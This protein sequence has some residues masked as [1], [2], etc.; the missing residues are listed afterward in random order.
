MA[1]TG[2]LCR[3]LDQPG[4]VGEHDLALIGSIVPEHRLG[5]VNG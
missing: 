5:V 4:D 1:E 2:P 3:P